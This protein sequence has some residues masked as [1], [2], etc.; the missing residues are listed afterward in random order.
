LLK[1]V[2][3][4]AVMGGAV[5]LTAAIMTRI[6]P[7]GLVGELL[8]VGGSGLVGAAVYAG[9][10]VLLRMEEVSLVGHAVVEWSRRLTGPGR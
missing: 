7:S 9:L 8:L 4:S 10:A 6:V 2:G 5:Q 3:A 1:A